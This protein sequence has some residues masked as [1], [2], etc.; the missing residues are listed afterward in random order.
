MIVSERKL[1]DY[2][3]R[4]V[5]A[6]IVAATRLSIGNSYLKLESKDIEFI[7]AICYYLATCRPLS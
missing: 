2:M 4:A 3:R 5:A 7:V 1:S 6:M